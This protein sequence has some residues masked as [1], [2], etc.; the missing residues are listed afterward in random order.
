MCDP[1]TI[2]AAA[3]AALSMGQAAMTHIGTNRAYAAN[4]QAAN[5]GYAQDQNALGQQQ[6]Q[7]DQE[8]S[9]SA[10]DTAISTLQAQ[11]QIAASAS[12]SGLASSS[13]I[14]SVN[15]SMFGIGRQVDAEKTNDFNTRQAIAASRTEADLKRQNQINS[16]TRSS[17][18]E[19]ALGIAQ[20]GAK[21]YSTYQSGRGA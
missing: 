9:Q 4:E 5:L 19:L 12:S 7:L 11:G 14:H 16:R 18:L 6:V 21:G 20:A 3:A 8:R 1:L 13:L 10:L 17:G 15:A 2:S